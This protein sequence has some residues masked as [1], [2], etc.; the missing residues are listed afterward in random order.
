L[1]AFDARLDAIDRIVDAAAAR[2]AT[3]DRTVRVE[4]ARGSFTGRATRLTDAGYLVVT[5]DDG[6]EEVVTAGDVV[7]LR[8]IT[9]RPRAS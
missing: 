5:R 8:P 4:L 2:S 7:H 3:L 6:G 1:R 9:D